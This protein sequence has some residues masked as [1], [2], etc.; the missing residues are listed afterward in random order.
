MA[1][2]A[3]LPEGTPF[4]IGPDMRPR[5]PLTSYFFDLSKY[6]GASSLQD[7][8]YDLMALESFLGA[9][10]EPPTDLLSVTE[11]D[12]V[13]Y[14]RSRTS[15]QSVPVGAATWRRNRVS[16]DGFYDWTVD[17][18]LLP[19]RPCRPRR[20]GRDALSRESAQD[21]DVRHLTYRQWQLLHRVG[22]GGDLPDGSPDPRFRGRDR[23][24]NMSAAEAT[25]TSGMRLRE[26]S[27][28]FD[29]EV[30]GTR[31]GREP[32]AVQLQA[33]AKYGFAREVWLQHAVLRS[34]DLYRRT[35]RTTVVAR[36][37]RTLW[38]RRAECSW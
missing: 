7:H 35:E 32:A 36:A 29:I 19:Q 31:P 23:L 20:N 34:I 30:P 27:C 22:L 14:R 6:V 16:I 9:V 33:V 10:L 11:E 12:L 24:R 18:G 15:L 5:K 28:L 3:A 21:L 37:H 13:A 1:H 25:V 17:C 4:F 8:T 2:P 26:F 38:R